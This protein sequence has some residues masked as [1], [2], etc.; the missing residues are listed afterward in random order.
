MLIGTPIGTPIGSRAATLYP[1]RMCPFSRARRPWTRSTEPGG[2][3]KTRCSCAEFERT[4]RTRAGLAHCRLQ[5]SGLLS[6]PHS[7]RCPEA[8]G[9]GSRGC[10]GSARFGSVWHCTARHG[11]ARNGSARPHR[12]RCAQGATT[13]SALTGLRTRD[14][15]LLENRLKRKKQ[16]NQKVPKLKT[17]GAAPSV[18][19]GCAVQERSH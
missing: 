8:F 18:S 1:L 9:K 5:P 15:F 19:S 17:S 7:P 12:D 11:T 10:F 16:T 3:G 2:S 14:L 4:P 13:A 6:G